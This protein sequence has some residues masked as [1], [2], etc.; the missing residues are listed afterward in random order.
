MAP[1]PLGDSRLE[2]PSCA[3]CGSDE[4]RLMYSN[5]QDLLYGT[6]GRF[7]IVRCLS[8]ELVYLHPR[9]KAEHVSDHY[10]LT[11]PAYRKIDRS[12]LYALFHLVGPI[13]YRLSFGSEKITV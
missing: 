2:L 4:R 11:Y 12:L 3:L 8:C 5:A 10:P 1:P 6:A 13:P 9:P 7:S